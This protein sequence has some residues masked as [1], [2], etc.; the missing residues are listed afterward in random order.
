MYLFSIQC[1]VGEGREDLPRDAP[2]RGQE[3][4]EAP[5]KSGDPLKVDFP[6]FSQL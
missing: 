5:L 3:V 2:V 6:H 4:R 1:W